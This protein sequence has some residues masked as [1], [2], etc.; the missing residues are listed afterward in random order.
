MTHAERQAAAATPTTARHPARWRR[1]RRRGTHIG[2][3]HPFEEAHLEPQRGS[4]SGA[5]CST[6]SA[7][8]TGTSR[9]LGAARAGL[10]VGQHPGPLTAGQARRSAPVQP[11]RCRTPRILA[12]SVIIHACPSPAR[13]PPANRINAVLMRVFRRADGIPSD[14][15]ISSAVLP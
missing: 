9:L 1:R 4:M 15:L 14:S 3:A 11:A 5:A 6:V 8:R 13:R 7:V 2:H 12:L 10:D